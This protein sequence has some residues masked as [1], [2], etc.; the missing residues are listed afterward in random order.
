MASE[1]TSEDFGSSAALLEF[2]K[3]KSD[4]IERALIPQFPTLAVTKHGQP[5]ME[6]PVGMVLHMFDGHRKFITPVD[7]E[8]LLND[9]ILNRMRIKIEL[10]RG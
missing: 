10:Y 1:P 9:G 2:L 8:M 6:L 7:A 5:I 3:E 4:D